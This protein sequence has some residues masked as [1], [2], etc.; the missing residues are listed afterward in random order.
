MLGILGPKLELVN[1]TSCVCIGVGS[2][3]VSRIRDLGHNVLNPAGGFNILKQERAGHCVS[4]TVAQSP[5][6]NIFP[7]KKWN[8]NLIRSLDPTAN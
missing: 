4:L 6:R 5:G 7:V 8:L 3:V 2:S 1:K